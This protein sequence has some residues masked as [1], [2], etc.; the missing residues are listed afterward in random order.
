[1]RTAS[2]NDPSELDFS[3]V[4]TATLLVTAPDG[5]QTGFNPNTGKV[6]QTA[7]DAAY[8]VQDNAVDTDGGS[9]APTSVTYFVDWGFPINGSYTVQLNGLALGTYELAV[10]A[11][12]I[13]GGREVS[14]VV[15][16]VASVGST[17]SFQIQYVPTPGATATIMRLATFQSTLADIA[18]SL[19]LG[20]IDNAGIA[21]ALSS[22]IQAASSAAS[23][24][25][26]QTA[27]NVLNAFLNQLNAQTGK[28]ITGVAP[29]VLLEDANSVISQL[30]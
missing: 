8:F 1:V 27:G 24:G 23:S 21:N 30:P 7:S 4:D 10:T 26:N 25:Q 16:G 9:E 20:L 11:F 12:N 18:N 19:A 6:V 13:N 22:K 3:V 15:N 14:A 28:H 2:G 5:T 17:S 29:Q